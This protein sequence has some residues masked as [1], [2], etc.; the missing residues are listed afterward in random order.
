MRLGFGLVSVSL[1]LTSLTFA[2]PTISYPPIVSVVA[3]NGPGQPVC[4]VHPSINLVPDPG[5]PPLTNALFQSFFG[6][7]LSP[8]AK[9]ATGTYSWGVTD[10]TQFGSSG[11]NVLDVFIGDVRDLSLQIDTEFVFYNGQVL[12][13]TVDALGPFQ[14]FDAEGPFV[15]GETSIGSPVGFVGYCCSLLSGQKPI[16]LTLPPGPIFSDALSGSILP[17][18]YPR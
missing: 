10:I 12:C 4:T 9:G 2:N 13:C 18:I 14:L 15:V 7:N 6:A 11:G 17:S 8:S 1:A 5:Q 3:C 16:P